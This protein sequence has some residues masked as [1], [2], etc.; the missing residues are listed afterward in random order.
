M[1]TNAADRSRNA[2]TDWPWHNEMYKFLELI[3]LERA[4]SYFLISYE[5]KA[6]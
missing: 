6:Y 1:R 3:G 5:D 2:E 4:F